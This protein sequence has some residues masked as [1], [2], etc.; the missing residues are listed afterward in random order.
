MN[1]LRISFNRYKRQM[2]VFAVYT[3]TKS[4]GCPTATGGLGDIKWHTWL[5]LT[6]LSPQLPSKFIT[7]VKME[8][9]QSPGEGWCH[10]VAQAIFDVFDNT[11]TL[12]WIFVWCGYQRPGL[13]PAI[14]NG[15]W[16]SLPWHTIRNRLTV[17]ECATGHTTRGWKFLH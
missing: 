13:H 1:F 17:K 11:E 9:N 12:T 2:N 14:P 3:T 7:V 10:R 8:Q 4:P 16:M 15:H 5:F 6:A